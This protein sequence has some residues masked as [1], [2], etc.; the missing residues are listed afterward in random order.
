MDQ[1]C[2]TRYGEPKIC[3]CAKLRRGI[4]GYLIHR[5]LPYSKQPPSH[6]L[7]AKLAN[8]LA[9]RI[10]ITANNCSRRAVQGV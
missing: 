6:V 10:D 1:I 5:N 9:R 3:S 7:P 8:P 4:E 2:L